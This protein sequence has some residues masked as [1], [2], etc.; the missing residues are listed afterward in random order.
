MERYKEIGRGSTF[1]GTGSHLT[2][3]WWKIKGSSRH[4][5]CLP[6]FLYNNC[7]RSEHS[8]SRERRFI[9]HF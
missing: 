3:E 5:P 2:C 1:T 8:T 9:T 4:D 6:Y 7:S